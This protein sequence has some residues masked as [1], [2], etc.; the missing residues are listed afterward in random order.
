M[1]NSQNRR[2]HDSSIKETQEEQLHNPIIT[3][4]GKALES[5]GEVVLLLRT[6]LQEL[7]KIE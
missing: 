7:E 5:C 3:S 2:E 1:W 6:C 4:Q